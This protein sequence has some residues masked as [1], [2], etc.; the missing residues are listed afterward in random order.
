MDKTSRRKTIIITGAAGGIGQGLSKH[1]ASLG[2]KVGMID[3]NPI[4]KEIAQ[5]ID[6]TMVMPV[7]CD[8]RDSAQVDAVIT[9]IED[10]LGPIDAL[11]NN[12]GIVANIAPIAKMKD[13]RWANELA[14]NLSA[15]FYFIRNLAPKMAEKGWGRIINVSSA[16]ARSGLP[17]QIG[18]ASTKSA[19]WGV[20]STTAAEF[21]S[22]GVTC[23]SI[24]PGVIATPTV[25][26]MPAHIQEGVKKASVLGRFG[27]IEE[28]AHLVAFLCSE[29]AGFITGA[30]ID[31][32]GG[33]RLNNTSLT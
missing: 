23:N 33:Y 21:G 1:M 2:W 32:D 14:V 24:L 27:E 6:D 22:K 31:I 9:R 8:I 29:K 3:I 28:I 10:T 20:T 25:L 16:A 15:A 11:V 12:A 4:I 26:S 5:A 7:V 17:A 30:E 19:L 13:N 18:Y